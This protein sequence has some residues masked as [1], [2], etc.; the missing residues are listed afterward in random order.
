MNLSRL[1]RTH[2]PS[3]P[4]CK[5]GKPS[6]SRRSTLM[7]PIEKRCRKSYPSYCHTNKGVNINP[8]VLKKMNLKI[9]IC[10]GC[11]K[12]LKTS[13]GEIPFQL[14]DICISRKEQR[15]FFDKIIGDMSTP[16]RETDSY[17]HLNADCI[18][19]VEKAFDPHHIAYRKT[20]HL[21]T[22]IKKNQS[23]ISC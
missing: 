3:N 7:S 16:S 13:I 9:K 11:H 22:F 5:G 10:Q 19:A 12:P 17:Y 1:L 8:F 6:T 14:Y 15:P 4:G 21:T 23:G 18:R 20:L 2:M